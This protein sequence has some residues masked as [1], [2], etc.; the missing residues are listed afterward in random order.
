MSTYDIQNIYGYISA[1]YIKDHKDQ[2]RKP[3]AAI[4]WT[5]SDLYM[6]FLIDMIQ[7]FIPVM[8]TG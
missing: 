6:Y 8:S 5:A 4:Q 3:V 2:D 1:G 7:Y